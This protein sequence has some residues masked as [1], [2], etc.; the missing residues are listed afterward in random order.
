MIVD[1]RAPSRAAWLTGAAAALPFA[2]RA[3]SATVLKVGIGMIDTHAQGYY[4]TE[5]GLFKKAGLNVELHQL[6]FGAIIA[7]AVAGG[8]LQI[9]SSNM[10]SL[11]A[12]HQRGIPFV[13]IAP[14]AAY[15]STVPTEMLVTV[16]DSA[17]RAAKDLNGKVIGGISIGGLEQLAISAFVDKNGGDSSTLKFVQVPTGALVTALQQGRIS[18]ADL[19]EPE[20]SAERDNIR[21]LGNTFEGIAPA[22]LESAWFTTDDWL[23]KNKDVARR[24]A[25]AVVAAGQWAMANPEAAGAIVQ[26]YV[27]VKSDRVRTRYGTKLDAASAQIVFDAALR[28]KLLGTV[29]ASDLMWSGK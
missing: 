8:E 27:G 24:F 19:P 18:A 3:Q 6:Q 13:V 10:L 9:G 1:G 7:A 15:D 25:G 2:V 14:G 16:R 17:I 12:G 20:L 23:A 26:K 28:Y 11:A 21:I 4:A 22:F 29:R 5:L